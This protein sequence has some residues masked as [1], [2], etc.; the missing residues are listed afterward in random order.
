MWGE[1]EENEDLTRLS[2]ITKATRRQTEV[3][4]WWPITTWEATP[5]ASP[6]TR[7]LLSTMVGQRWWSTCVKQW[8]LD[9]LV[10]WALGEM[11]FSELEDV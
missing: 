5:E 4:M 11:D 10:A 1:D 7:Q 9:I 6:F 3:G 2:C 8:L